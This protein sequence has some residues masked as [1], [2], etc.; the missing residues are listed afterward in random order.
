MTKHLSHCDVITNPF[1]ALECTC[2]FEGRVI[3]AAQRLAIESAAQKADAAAKNIYG[4]TTRAAICDEIAVAIRE[5]KD[6]P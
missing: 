1:G 6:K 3:S 2:D 4:P 5:M